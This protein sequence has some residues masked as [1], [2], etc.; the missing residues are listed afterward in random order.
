MKGPF[1][2][3]LIICFVG[4]VLLGFGGKQ[5]STTKTFLKNAEETIGTI[6][7]I[8]ESEALSRSD[9]SGNNTL[10]T[11]IFS[12]TPQGSFKTIQVKSVTSSGVRE[13]MGRITVPFTINQE[14]LLIYP[15]D[16]PFQAKIKT[17]WSIWLFPVLLGSGGLLFFFSGGVIAL[18]TYRKM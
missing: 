6:V 11:P 4:I 18:C 10:Y 5:Y 17:F 12:F 15:K 3:G 13:V 14:I 2:L 16:D 8:E 1:I 9:S 7:A